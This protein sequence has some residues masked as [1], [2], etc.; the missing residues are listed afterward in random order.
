QVAMRELLAKNARQKSR[1]ISMQLSLVLN[2]AYCDVVRGQLSAQEASKKQNKQGRL[3][4]DGMP[5]LLTATAFVERVVA[6]HDA[7]EKKAA[8]LQTRKATAVERSAALKEWRKLE[9]A[10]KARNDEIRELFRADV[11]AWE[12]E[13][14]RAKALHQRPGWKK[15]VL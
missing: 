13:R 12:V 5:R 3:V 9:K 8:E 15:P 11:T 4:G 6:F 14:N 7:A 2:G 1:M 10:R